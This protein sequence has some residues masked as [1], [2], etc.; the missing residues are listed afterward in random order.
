MVFTLIIC[1]GIGYSYIQSQI[2][3]GGTAIANRQAWKIEENNMVLDTTGIATN[4]SI[5]FKNSNKKVEAHFTASLN[6]INDYYGF[7]FDIQNNGTIDAIIESFSINGLSEAEAINLDYLVTYSNGETINVNDV[8]KANEKIT[9][10]VYVKH[11]IS[12]TV[13]SGNYNLSLKINFTKQTDTNATTDTNTQLLTL[14]A[15]N[16]TIDNTIDFSLASPIDE[17]TPNGAGLRILSGTE[18]NQYPIY[19]YRGNV[20]NNNVLFSNICWKIVKTTSTGGIK[21]IYNGSPIDG[22]CTATGAATGIL[23]KFNDH[24]DQKSSI[25]KVGYMYEDIYSTDFIEYD[26]TTSET[27]Y[28]FAESYTYDEETKMYTLVNYT[29]ETDTE[30]LSTHHYTCLN[31]DTTCEQLKYVYYV[32]TDTNKYYYVALTNNENEN[33]V[34]SSIHNNVSNSIAKIELETWFN[35][36]LSN[37]IN[38]LEDEIYCADRT[39]S[40][41]GGWNNKAILIGAASWLYFGNAL[42]NTDYHLD[43]PNIEDSFTVSSTRGNGKNFYPIGLITRNETTLAGGSSSANASFYLNNGIKYFT[44]TPNRFTN[45]YADLNAV[46]DTGNIGAI[47]ATE[48]NLFLRPV[49]TLN[50]DVRISKGTGLTTD[51]FVIK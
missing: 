51:P 36:N 42:T 32:I 38:Y 44:M 31:E 25:N 46:L 26:S 28:K 37:S 45:G 9:I 21:L 49:I 3:L 40:T 6:S 1:M 30:I 5:K 24:F 39:I 50:K 23:S 33:T 13:T 34:L 16:A 15:A 22:A 47:K 11:K 14:L 48:S 41:Y 12:S 7:S 20:D 17:S 18:T 4:D 35:N 27:K 8:L 10:K 2:M 19:F 43:C 29:E